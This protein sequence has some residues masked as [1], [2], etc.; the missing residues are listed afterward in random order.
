MIRRFLLATVT[1]TFAASIASD[2]RAALCF[3]YTK[4]GGG[5]SVAQIDL[6]KPNTC[7][8]FA[9]YEVGSDP[10]ST[11]LGAGTGS[12]C[13]S[14]LDPMLIYHYTYQGCLPFEGTDNYWESATCRLQLDHNGNLPT[15]FSVCRGSLIIGKPTV[16][17]AGTFL[18]K[19]IW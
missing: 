15:Q 14:T 16:G 17:N 2:A 7:E 10:A 12:L 9:I 4:S 6:P 5:V 11:L 8:T 1:L 3:Q 13:M 19:T 18:I